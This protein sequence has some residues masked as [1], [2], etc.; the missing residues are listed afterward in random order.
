MR[1]RITTAADIAA[2]TIYVGPCREWQGA[3]SSSTG[4]GK[5]RLRGVVMDAHRACW[6]AAHGPIPDGLQ[7]MHSCDNRRCVHLE[8]LSLGTRSDNMRDAVVKGRLPENFRHGADAPT[9]RLT[10]EQVV[11]I[12]RRLAGGEKCTTLASEFGVVSTAISKIKHGHSWGRALA[13]EEQVA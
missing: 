11:D 8:H 7:V 4:Y 6:I 10:L 9:A 2:R 5:L 3:V 13:A 12:K 1:G